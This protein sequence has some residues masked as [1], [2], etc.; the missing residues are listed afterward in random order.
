MIEGE[1]R[2]SDVSIDPSFPLNEKTWEPELKDL[3]IN[4][5]QDIKNWILNGPIPDYKGLLQTKS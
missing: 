1:K 4:T 3:F 5:P 2:C